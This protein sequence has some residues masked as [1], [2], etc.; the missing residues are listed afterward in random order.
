MRVISHEPESCA[1]A[2]S[3]TSANA[4]IVYQ[5]KMRLS[6]KNNRK[7]FSAVHNYLRKTFRYIIM[8]VEVCPKKGDAGY[9]I[10]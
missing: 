9:E 5:R 8:K 2:N 6:T 1:S 3:A 10:T 7:S 4:Y